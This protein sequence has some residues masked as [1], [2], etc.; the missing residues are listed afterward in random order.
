MLTKS[1]DRIAAQAAAIDKRALEELER[2]LLCSTV[3]LAHLEQ[4]LSCNNVVAMSST[5]VNLHESKNANNLHESKNANNLLV[6]PESFFVC[7]NTLLSLR[8]W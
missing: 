8:T 3:D 7:Q 5:L 4:L 1:I 6:L 2:A